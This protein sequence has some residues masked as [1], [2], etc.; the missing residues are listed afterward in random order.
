[1]SLAESRVCRTEAAKSKKLAVRLVSEHKEMVESLAVPTNVSPTT[2]ATAQ[3]VKRWAQQVTASCTSRGM[4]EGVWC[5][6]P[7]PAILEHCEEVLGA[8]V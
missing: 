3:N 4:V 1:M 8:P 5:S 2:E 7:C 6:A